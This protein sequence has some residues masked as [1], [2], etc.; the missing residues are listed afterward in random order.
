MLA[1]AFID[2]IMSVLTG[3]AMPICKY[4]S[5]KFD[6]VYRDRYCS[7]RCQL[8]SR[9]TV[10]SDGCWVWN[11]S[12]SKAG[13]GVLNYKGKLLSSH[14]AS[15][16]EHHGAILEGVFVCHKCDNP[17]CVNPEHLFLGTA[18]DNAQDMGAKG[19]GA[20]TGKKF[21]EEYRKKLSDAH[22]QSAYV[23]TDAHR[24]NLKKA[25]K[26]RWDN[27]EYAEKMTA[28][29]KSAEFRS[30]CK[31]KRREMERDLCLSS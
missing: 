30:S 25:L 14:R 12:K 4:C 10:A 5:N 22:K 2:T 26:K 9:V 28:L 21:S 18:A 13:Y 17:A 27:P 20:W 8:L 19:R 11:G 6:G 15:Y 3:A 16:A 24:E 31:N 1:M 29:Y 23:M 7:L